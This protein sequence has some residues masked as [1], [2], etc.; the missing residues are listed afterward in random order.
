MVG[1]TVLASSRRPSSAKPGGAAGDSPNT[2][3][4]F[5][6]VDKWSNF[7]GP[8]PIIKTLGAE[9]GEKVFMNGWMLTHSSENVLLRYRAD[10]S[11]Q[12]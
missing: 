12:P 3:G 10:L 6:L 9:A 2:Y 1:E 5:G 11:I 7:D 8:H 4:I